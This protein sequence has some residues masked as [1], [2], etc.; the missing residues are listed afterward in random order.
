M[1]NMLSEEEI[2][3]QDALKILET[4]DAVDWAIFKREYLNLRD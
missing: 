1:R 4:D 2:D 3:I